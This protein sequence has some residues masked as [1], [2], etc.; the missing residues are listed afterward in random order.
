MYIYD[1]SSLRV[2]M[3]LTEEWNVK[4]L[5]RLGWR[6]YGKAGYQ[7]RSTAGCCSLP[8]VGDVL[9]NNRM[10]QPMISPCELCGCH[11][12]LYQHGGLANPT[13]MGLPN[14]MWSD[15]T[16]T[17]NILNED[18]ADGW[19]RFAFLTRWNSV[20]LQVFLSATLQ[21]GMF[22]EV[23]HPQALLG[24]LVSI[25]WKFQFTKIVSEFVINF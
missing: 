4:E 10:A 11:D 14:E 12:L 15:T 1:I 5:M 18:I 17:V 8:I 7:Q 3:D 20:H 23:S 2:K 25:S 13:A 22:P 24:S 16:V 9:G 19:R 21:G 6:K